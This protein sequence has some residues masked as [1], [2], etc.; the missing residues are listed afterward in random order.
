MNEKYKRQSFLGEKSQ[1]KI[2]QTIVGVV[3]LG[4]G[5]SPILQ[6]LL[7][8]GFKKIVVFD[9]DVVEESNTHRLVGI[10]YPDDV[11]NKTPKI[12]IAN[13][14]A[15]NIQGEITIETYKSTWQENPEKL[16]K[17]QIVLG[18]VDSFEQREQLEK[19]CRRFSIPYIDIGLGVTVRGEEAPQMGGQVILSMP[20]LPCM[21]C[22]GFITED[23]LNDE[24]SRYG[25]AGPQPQVI[26]ANGILSSTAVGIAVRLVT[27]WT[28]EKIRPVYMSYN[29]NTDE[30]VTHPRLQYLK[31]ATCT[32]Y[33]DDMLGEP[34]FTDL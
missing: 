7:H 15:K 4:G 28:K 3:G 22:M 1:E 27:G 20:G 13:R 29:A 11:I 5:G 21:R 2:E 33:T 6:Q 19:F 24:R 9:P 23:K 34:K 31:T 8:I 12:E 16:K 14:M 26:W 32:H 18:G 10:C 25:D 30:V 17:C